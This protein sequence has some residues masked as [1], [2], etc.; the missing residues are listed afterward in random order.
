MTKIKMGGDLSADERRKIMTNREFFNAIINANVSDELTAH[1]TAELEKLDA[2]NKARSSKPS[3][4]QLENEPIKAHLLEILAVKPMTANEIHNTDPN[5]SS[6]KISTLCGQ[7]AKE[8]KVSIQEIK[9]PK[10]GKR[11]QYSL[12]TE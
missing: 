12:V 5:L 10:V 1:A 8:G 2:R 7:L 11:N 4:I 3:K 6:S 9:V